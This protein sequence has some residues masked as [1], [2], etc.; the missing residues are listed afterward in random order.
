MYKDFY[1][2][3]SLP[4]ENTPDQRFFYDSE[5]HREA[6]SAIEYTIR[7]RKGLVLIT[8]M[9]G[10]GKTTVG[11]MMCDTCG[12][13]AQIVHIVPR[14]CSGIDLIRQVLRSLQVHTD[15]GEDYATML[16]KLA[17]C[18]NDKMQKRKPV[19][20]FIDEAQSLSDDALE[21]LRLLCNLDTAQQK[22]IQVVLIGQPELRQRISQP[23]YEALR[24][25]IVMAKQL[26][27]LVLDET[28]GYIPHRL[29]T[30]SNDPRRVQV[31]FSPD[32]I[33]EI[34]QATGG[35]P[36]LINVACDNCLLLGFVREVRQIT[37]QMVRQ[38]IEDMVPRFNDTIQNRTEPQSTLSMAGNI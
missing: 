27:P 14:H 33:K 2:L 37:P 32:A 28:T 25:R 22:L 13:Q 7:L 11:R 9:I 12:H 6:L 21:E 35:I 36:R 15:A 18:L 26:R 31:A 10:S 30:A 4:F 19:A 17:T 34:H 29:A 23:R 16:E 3:H 5:Q 1:N 8:G 20:L 38:V 24:Q